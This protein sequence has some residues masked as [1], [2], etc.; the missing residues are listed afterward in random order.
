VIING[1]FKEPLKSCDYKR[2]LKGAIDE[3]TLLERKNLF[4]KHPNATGSLLGILT[5]TVGDIVS[6]RK[7][8]DHR[9]GL[10]SNS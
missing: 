2:L 10:V 1:S 8:I 4:K 7:N 5:L 9:F 3:L 6:L